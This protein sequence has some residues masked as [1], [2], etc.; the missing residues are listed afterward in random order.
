MVV[1]VYVVQEHRRYNNDTGCYEP[2]HDLSPAE[3]FGELR[4][5][6]TPTAGP[7]NPESIIKDLW[8][9]LQNFTSADYLLMVGNP[10]LCGLAT[11][12]ASEISEGKVQFLQWNG[13]D[14]KYK[15]VEAQVF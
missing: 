13:R 8:D 2:V 3:E 12:V 9:N 6:L 5:L 4:Y 1:T 7:W 11:A 10:I 15:P 14:R